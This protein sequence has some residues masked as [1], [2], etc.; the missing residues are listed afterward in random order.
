MFYDFF[1]FHQKYPEL[2]SDPEELLKPVEVGEEL[3]LVDTGY[4]VCRV[5]EAMRRYRT[6]PHGAQST[7][8]FVGEERSR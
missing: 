8:Y 7:S 2:V 3:Q 1:F 5:E 4:L 6:V